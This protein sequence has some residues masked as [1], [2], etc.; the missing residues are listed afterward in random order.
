MLV[1]AEERE[2]GDGASVQ[3]SE[4]IVAGSPMP[5]LLLPLSYPTARPAADP[6]EATR[7]AARA[8]RG[9]V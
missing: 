1:V 2:P 6:G 5:V 3:G 4:D 7:A 8:L 9:R